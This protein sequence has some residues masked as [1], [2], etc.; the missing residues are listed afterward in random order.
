M[1]IGSERAWWRALHSAFNP[2]LDRFFTHK[3]PIETIAFKCERMQKCIYHT[4]YRMAHPRCMLL[5]LAVASESI[6]TCSITRN[7]LG[8]LPIYAMYAMHM[9]MGKK[10]GEST[11]AFTIW[12]TMHSTA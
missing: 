4:V 12:M 3:S 1:H 7:T 8:L 6:N 5:I 11:H 10:H 9:A 2:M